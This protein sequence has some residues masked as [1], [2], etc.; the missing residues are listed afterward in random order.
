[1]FLLLFLLT[2]TSH[3]SCTDPSYIV[4]IPSVGEKLFLIA[5]YGQPP[6]LELWSTIHCSLNP[7][8]KSQTGDLE[9]E[10][11][12][13]LSKFLARNAIFS[14]GREASIAQ[15]LGNHRTYS[16]LSYMT[17]HGSMAGMDEKNSAQLHME[18]AWMF[19]VNTSVISINENQYFDMLESS[20]S[21]SISEIYFI[22]PLSCSKLVWAAASSGYA[23]SR[24]WRMESFS[25]TDCS[26]PPV[27][28]NVFMRHCRRDSLSFVSSSK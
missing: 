27:T 9:L 14:F 17:S 5:Q 8:V 22:S 26:S 21:V 7:H 28:C 3:D 16:L 15:K 10:T 19:I 12:H 18:I 2:S 1:M 11:S 13:W 23:L 4:N 6:S 20:T 25:V 24:S